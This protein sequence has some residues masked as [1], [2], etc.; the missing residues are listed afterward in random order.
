LNPIPLTLEEGIARLRKLGARWSDDKRGFDF[1]ER[2]NKSVL[3]VSGLHASLG[4]RPILKGVDLEVRRSECISIIGR[5]GSGK[6]TLIKHFN[7][8]YRP[9]RGSVRVLGRST[10]GVTV[11]ELARQVGVAFQNSNDQFFKYSVR[12]EVLVGPRVLGVYDQAWIDEMIRLFSLAEL[13]DRPPYRLSEGEKKRAAIASVLA[14]KPEIIVLDEPT[15]GQDKWF[16]D[17]LGDVFHHLRQLGRTIVLV[18][19]DL[20][21]AEENTERW[22]VLWDGRI[23]ADGSAREIMSDRAVIERTG[24]RPTDRFQIMRGLQNYSIGMFG[25][26][27]SV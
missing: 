27:E 16:R 18:T 9:N 26:V 1:R 10:Q 11:R 21:F 24:L 15:I 7:G 13:L 23:I 8:L 12:D 3:E 5:N 25:N 20:E 6:T 4:R 17:T 22:V 2:S 19:N 14:A